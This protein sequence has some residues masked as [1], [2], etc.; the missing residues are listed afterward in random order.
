MDILDI[1]QEKEINKQEKKIDD[2]GL[3]T[4]KKKI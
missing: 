3:S 1:S 4:K 2:Y